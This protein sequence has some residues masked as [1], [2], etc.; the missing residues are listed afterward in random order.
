MKLIQREGA[1][2]EKRIAKLTGTRRTPGSGA[3]W[4]SKGDL[5]SSTELVEVKATT[6]K[7]YVLKLATLEK[8]EAE[9]AAQDRDP[10]LIIEFTTP[11]GRRMY[12][13]TRFYGS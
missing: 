4:H 3:R 11:R 2:A 10:S 9:A 6:K 8:I 5:K 12:R 1:R 13:V 7:S